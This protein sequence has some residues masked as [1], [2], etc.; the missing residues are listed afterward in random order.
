MLENRL[1]LIAPVLSAQLLRADERVL[2]RVA[3]AVCQFAVQRTGLAN[4]PVV[5]SI[6]VLILNRAT[7]H[8][9]RQR[10]ESLVAQLDELQWQL[11]DAVERGEVDNGAYLA[12]FHR[13][14]AVHAVWF[15]LDDNPVIAAI[16]ATYEAHAATDDLP[17]LEELIHTLLA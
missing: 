17:G 6:D 2:R 12:A 11:Q 9:L 8:E 3:L 10:V 13:A 4:D 15:A 1:E 5:A 14:R 7:A 16:E